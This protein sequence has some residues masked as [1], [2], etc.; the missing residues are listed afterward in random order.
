MK[1]IQMNIEREIR[2]C[3]QLVIWTDCDRE[4]ENIGSEV[5]NIC[6]AMKSRLRVL[7][8]YFSAIIPR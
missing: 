1:D 7:R 6:L 5:A 3:D 8:A 4:G 2:N